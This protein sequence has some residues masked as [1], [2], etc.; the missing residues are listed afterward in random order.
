MLPVEE[1]NAEQ[2]NQ[3]TKEEKQSEN[4]CKADKE[5]TSTKRSKKQ[6][7]KAKVPWTEDDYTANKLKKREEL[8]AVGKPTW[9]SYAII[10][11]E[12]EGQNP[13]SAEYAYN[14]QC[15]HYDPKEGTVTENRREKLGTFIETLKTNWC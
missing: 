10:F 2:T 1:D 12:D 5:E 8:E 9:S 15:L 7:K 13:Q 3:A 14:I 11:D 4:N 6:P